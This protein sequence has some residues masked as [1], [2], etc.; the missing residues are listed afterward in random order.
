MGNKRGVRWSNGEREKESER[1]A[2][3]ASIGA[4]E[5]GKRREEDNIERLVS[6]KTDL[7]LRA[8]VRERQ[9]KKEGGT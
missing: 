3:R 1:G 2:D 7:C 6:K 5:R 8:R 9:C 4:Y